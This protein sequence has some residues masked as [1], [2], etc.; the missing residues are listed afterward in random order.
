MKDDTIYLRHILDAIEKIEEYLQGMDHGSLVKDQKTL[1][2]V[3]RELEVIGEAS[4]HF[5]E[6][7]RQSY[8]EI[9]YPD[10]VGMRNRLIHEYFNVDIKEVW[11]TCQS[12]LPPLKKNVKAILEKMTAQ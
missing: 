11:R 8:P 10:I 1:D 4:K 5:S 6:T 9:P 3:V 12:D 7:F 2:A